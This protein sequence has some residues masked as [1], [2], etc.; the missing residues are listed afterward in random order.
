MSTDPTMVTYLPGVS[1]CLIHDRF[2][3]VDRTTF[4]VWAARRWRDW[5]LLNVLAAFVVG[6]S[7]FFQF[8]A[9]SYFSH[10]FTGLLVL[11]AAWKIDHR[12]A[13]RRRVYMKL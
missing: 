4:A 3:R 6:T 9:A 5:S 7:S 11:E 1:R 8:N 10:P 2:E 13:L 12:R